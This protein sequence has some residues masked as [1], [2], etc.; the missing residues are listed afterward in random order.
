MSQH[1]VVIV[2]CKA[3]VKGLVKTRLA[4]NVGEAVALNIYTVLLQHIFEQFSKAAHDVIYC[5]DGNRELMNNHNI[6]TIAQHGENLGQR[7]CNAVTDVGEYDHYIVIGADA[8]FVDL[9]VIDE[10]LVQLNKNDVVIG[11]A[12]DGGYYLIAMKTLHQELFHNISWSTPHVLT[13]TLETCTEMGLRAHLL[14]SL[15]DVDT[16]QD[17]I[18]LEAPSSKHQGVVAKLR[19]LI[20]ALCCLFCVSSAAQADGGWTRKQGELFG[21]VAFQTLS[22]SSAYNLNGTKSTTSR[23]SLWSVSL[24]AEYGLDSNVMLSLNAPMYRSSKVEDY[25][26]V[27]NIGDIAIDVRYGVVTGDWPVS[28]GVGLELP[29]GDERGFATYSGVVDPLVDLRPVYLPTGDG[30]L[31]LWINAGM[32]HSFWPTEAFVSIDAGYNIRGLSASDYTRR[33][34]NGQFTNQYRASIKGGYKVLSP[35]WV[36]LSVYRFAT[37]GTPQPGRFTFNG[38]GEGVE[39]NA[40]DIGLLYE[41]GTVS[42]SVDASSAFTTPRAIYGGVNVF[43]GA[44]ITL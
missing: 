17:I 11:P 41:I 5:I 2:M 40:W 19:N 30:E 37:A 28:I 43:F 39:Y 21:K 3:P 24:Y 34:D 8:P 15:T 23:Y 33:F 36:T 26:A 13:Q 12:H 25:D 14:H 1:S 42:V 16:L 35:L 9:D 27:G 44:M 4:V 22:T 31:N 10:S 38:L 20:A 7:I 18:A 6:A 29:T 32:S